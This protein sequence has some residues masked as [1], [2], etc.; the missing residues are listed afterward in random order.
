MLLN[1]KSKW[2]MIIL[3]LSIFYWPTYMFGLE[4]TSA[5]KSHYFITLLLTSL[6][7][8]YVK[9]KLK[10]P[11]GI[12]FLLPLLISYIFIF[13]QR[14]PEATFFELGILVKFFIFFVFT[15][16]IYMLFNGLYPKKE[17]VNDISEVFLAVF[18]LQIFFIFLQVFFGDNSFLAIWN[19]K[20]VVTAWGM[21][22]PGTFDW[23]YTTCF[24][25]T[26]FIIYFTYQVLLGL[27]VKRSIVIL[28]L[29]F[30]CIL[31]SQSKVGY[32]T[33]IASL[34]YFYFLLIGFSLQGKYRL[35]ILFLSVVFLFIGIILYSSIDISYVSNFLTMFLDGK[36]DGST[37]TRKKQALLALSQGLQ[38]WYSGSPQALQG[39]IIENGYLD[40]FFRY[41]LFGFVSYILL[42]FISYFYS[43]FVLRKVVFSFKRSFASV[44]L[45]IFMMSIHISLFSMLLYT[46]S[47]TI[48]DGYK[49]SFW[50]LILLTSCF[51]VNKVCSYK[52]P[53]KKVKY[54]SVLNST[55]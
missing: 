41:G 6:A 29:S 45:L 51:W 32:V 44:E 28:V 22:P 43:L 20:A 52:C 13:F 18:Y 8:A 30:F 55:N 46:N 27:K 5:Q 17:S 15:L 37:G 24:F 42:L 49:A 39:V 47:G 16:L 23:V 26:F 38:Y 53:L 11:L 12:V 50:F 34:I 10:L 48:T 40:Y 3:L 21:R 1:R 36:L 14:I 7:F 31:L 4:T 2:V 54:N 9:P 25:L 19:H 35:F 33:T